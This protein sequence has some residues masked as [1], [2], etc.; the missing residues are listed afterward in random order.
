MKNLSWS[1]A[2]SSKTPDLPPHRPELHND[3]MVSADEQ[4]K[5]KFHLMKILGEGVALLC[6]STNARA[7][8]R[9]SKGRSEAYKRR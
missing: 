2:D 7:K 1:D 4:Y 3:C 9:M 8:N 6:R 5:R